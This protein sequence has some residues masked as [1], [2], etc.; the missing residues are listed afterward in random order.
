MTI[1]IRPHLDLEACV[2]QLRSLIRIPSVNPP[3]GGLDV[4][5]GRDPAGGETAA[6]RYCAEVLAGAGIESEVVELSAGRGSCVARLRATGTET[7]PPLILLSHLDVVPVDA[8]SWTRDPF[9]G[10]LVDGVVWGR[11]AVDM[12]NM[13]AM[14]LSV[15][16]ALHR[17]GAELRRDVIFAAV[18]D[19]EAGGTVGARGLVDTRPELFHD[20]GGRPAAA[21]LNEVGGYSITLG[22]QRFYTIQVAEKGIVWTRVRTTGTPGHGSMPHDDNAAIKLAAAIAAL[23]ADQARRPARVLPVVAGFLSALGLNEV[24]RQVE[25][26]PAAAAAALEARV[27]DPVM[28]R[29]IDA[30]LRD[31][32]TPTVLRAGK[33]VNVVA[34]SGEAEIDVR[35]LPGTDQEEL[36]AHLQRA[37]G[38]G[39][40]VEPVISL[41]AIE[42][43]D[44]AEIV[45]LM[46][47]ALRV[48]DPEGIPV[49]MMITPG[50]DAKALAGLGIP[51]YGFAPL[52][53]EADF[54]F[55]SLFHGHDE[56]VPVSALA[57]G[58]PVLAEVVAG[59]AGRVES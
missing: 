15:M 6:A 5:A 49:P 54:P 46:D 34:G 58:L 16:L 24:A 17:S 32:V 30:M 42:W 25:S 14:E 33:K 29:S 7:E 4:A 55:L 44:D 37:V 9:G 50:T 19:E 21:A 26:D 56:R 31:T 47:G 3:D 35:T 20:A 53:L 27:A 51:C 39:A 10:D 48:A 41:P 59:Y 45:A 40:V 13:V 23:V 22:G 57:F 8:E 38:D 1:D 52:R 43:P 11:G 28:R 12:K 36:L 18:A 2:D